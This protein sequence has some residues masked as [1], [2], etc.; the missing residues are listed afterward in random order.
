MIYLYGAGGH[1]KV[2]IDIIQQGGNSV[3]G[4]FDDDSTKTIW[5]FP[6]LIF[7]ALLIH[8]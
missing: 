1:A 5:N 2:I 3:E 8:P 6:T 7:P 4:I